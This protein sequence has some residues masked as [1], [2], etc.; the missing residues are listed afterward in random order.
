MVQGVQPERRKVPRRR[1]LKAGLIAFN[2]AATI[3]CQVRNL[4][5][6]GACLDVPSQIGIPDEF[7]LVVDH[8]RLKKKCR[9]IW[10]KPTRLGVEFE[11]DELA[12]GP[13]A[14]EPQSA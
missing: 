5:P 4:S 12:R 9:V 3:E 8:E 10:R 14:A 7:T 11:A 1:T 13:A 2:R 6:I